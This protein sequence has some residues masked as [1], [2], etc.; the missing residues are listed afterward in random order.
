MKCFQQLHKKGRLLLPII[1]SKKNER[2][3]SQKDRQDKL[4][5]DRLLISDT[6][7]SPDR[8]LVA[9]EKRG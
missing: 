9:D 1:L 8:G 2:A 4:L 7:E 5:E 3:S 6:H